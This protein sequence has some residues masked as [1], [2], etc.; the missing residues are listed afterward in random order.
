VARRSPPGLSRASL[1]L[2]EQAQKIME[3]M[4]DA[5]VSTDHLLL[6][7]ARTG[8]FG[9]DGEAIAGEIPRLRGGAK[10]TTADPEATYDALLKYGTDLTQAAREGKLDP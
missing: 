5:F 2:L 9:I 10:V 7:L 8:D 6:A 3:S 4:G 1:S